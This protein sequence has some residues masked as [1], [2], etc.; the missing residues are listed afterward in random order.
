MS[1]SRLVNEVK[2]T[3][4]PAVL[5]SYSIIFFLNNRFLATVLLVVTF[6]NFYA[7]LSG[8]LAIIIS[9]ALAKTMHLDSDT[10]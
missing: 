2:H 10:V 3:W 8:L 9:V 5:N 7:G 6:F 4:I 1:V